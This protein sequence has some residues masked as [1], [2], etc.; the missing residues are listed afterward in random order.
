MPHI[1]S[2]LLVAQLRDKF[3][4]FKDMNFL[5]EWVDAPE[6]AKYLPFCSSMTTM[7]FLAFLWVDPLLVIPRYICFLMYMEIFHPLIALPHRKVDGNFLKSILNRHVRPLQLHILSKCLEESLCY[8]AHV[9]RH[10]NYDQAIVI[11]QPN[12]FQYL[13]FTCFVKKPRPF[14]C[15]CYAMGISGCA[16]NNFWLIERFLALR[17]LMPAQPLPSIAHTY[18]FEDYGFL[19]HLEK[20]NITKTSLE[21]VTIL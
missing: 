14:Y 7:E 16:H 21:K 1:H 10:E 3:A 4:I 18:L 6:Y 17:M 20:Y 2:K 8:I 9:K 12:K 19:V 15:F 5:L 11:F 13:V